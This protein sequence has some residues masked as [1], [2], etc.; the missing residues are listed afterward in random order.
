MKKIFTLLSIA[1]L[2]SAYAQDVQ[3]STNQS[4]FQQLRAD[5][6]ADLL[7]V[8]EAATNPDGSLPGIVSTVLYSG[9]MVV[10]ADDFVLEN[11][12]KITNINILG[13]QT[14][15]N[16]KLLELGLRLFIYEDNNG[17]PNGVP[18]VDTPLFEANLNKNNPA[19]TI[20]QN[21]SNYIYS[22]NIS[23]LNPNLVLEKDKTYW[24]A[25]APKIDLAQYD[26]SKRF[27]WGAGEARNNPSKLID[28]QNAFSVGP[29]WT[30][31]NLLIGSDSTDGLIFALFGET[32]LGTGEV[33]S[34]VKDLTVY[35]NPASNEINLKLKSNKI[36]SVE[37]VDVTGRKI[38]VKLKN[39]N[40]V[41]VSSL[42]SGVFNLIVVDDLGNTFTEKVIKK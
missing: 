13:F 6:T 11:D 35:P 31:I 15:S 1:A 14:A 42:P 19:Y 10:S 16:L 33:Y 3:G 30:D 20:T 26:P 22:I 39:E 18:G 2:T 27:H 4:S 12:S 9:N 34:N 21:E 23:A 5:Q 29:Y 25:F 24:I 40:K 38:N 28:P 41:D 7:Y 17:E 36:K 37:L 32:A 8:Q